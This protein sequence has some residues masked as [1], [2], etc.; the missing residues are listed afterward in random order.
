M[1]DDTIRVNGI[2]API[3]IIAEAYRANVIHEP[4]QVLIPGVMR[5]Q[6]DTTPDLSDTEY[7]ERIRCVV[8]EFRMCDGLRR[9]G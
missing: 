1:I 4:T 6:F 9:C 8:R 2:D 3:P 5:V 7:V